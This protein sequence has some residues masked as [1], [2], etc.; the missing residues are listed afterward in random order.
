MSISG[1]KKYYSCLEPEVAKGTVCG[2]IE[3][4][5]DWCVKNEMAM[6]GL[7]VSSGALFLIVKAMEP[8]K[9]LFWVVMQENLHLRTINLVAV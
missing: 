3:T 6:Q 1:D 2:K 4:G 9:D 5:W 7:R 8:L